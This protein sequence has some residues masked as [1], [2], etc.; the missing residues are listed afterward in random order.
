MMEGGGGSNLVA[1]RHV[2]G[3]FTRGRVNHGE[4]FATDRI[5]KLI[6]DEDL[7]YQLKK[8]SNAEIIFHYI[9]LRFLS[10]F[11]D[12]VRPMREHFAVI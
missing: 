8:N 10:R 9:I 3:L 6:V 5:H 11:D 1:F 2:T 4:G 7:K 12:F